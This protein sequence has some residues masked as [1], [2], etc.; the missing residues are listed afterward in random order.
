MGMCHSTSGKQG[1]HFHYQPSSYVFTKDDLLRVL[2]REDELRNS[3]EVQVSSIRENINY[4]LTLS[5][6]KLLKKFKRK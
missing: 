1:F 4:I 2:R 6:G 5:T 3:T